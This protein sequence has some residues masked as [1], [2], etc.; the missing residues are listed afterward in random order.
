MTLEIIPA[1]TPLQFNELGN[2]FALPCSLFL[3][4]FLH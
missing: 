1:T 2:R 4:D 3:I